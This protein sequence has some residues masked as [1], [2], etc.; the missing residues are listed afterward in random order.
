MSTTH[1]APSDD[2]GQELQDLPTTDSG[3][4]R[5]RQAMQ[6]MQSLGEPDIDAVKDAVVAQPYDHSGSTYPEPITRIRIDGHPEFVTEVAK[7]FTEMLSFENIDTRLS[8]NL[9]Q[10]EDSETGELRDD[11]YALYISVADRG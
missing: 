7:F 3:T 1:D 2:Q 9:K 5:K 10:V 8:L 11:V 6:W 4:V